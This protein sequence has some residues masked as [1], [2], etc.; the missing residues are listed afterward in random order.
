MAKTKIPT[1][2]ASCS[3][4]T[5]PE[6][7]L[8]AKLKAI[9][10]AG[11]DAI[12]L[13]LPDL[14]SFAKSYLKKDGSNYDYPELCEA[15]EKVK[16]LCEECNLK[17]LIL[18]PFANFEGWPDGSSEKE[19]AWKRA[20]GWIQIMEAVGTDMLQVCCCSGRNP[21]C[22][23]KAMRLTNDS[24]IFRLARL[25]RQISNRP[26][27]SLRVILRI[28]RIFWLPKASA[29]HMRTGAGQHM[30]QHGERCGRSSRRLTGQILGY[31]WIHFKLQGASGQTL[32]QSRD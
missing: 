16:Q 30:R 14:L 24:T 13:S 15:G 5:K 29:L 3:I 28:S 31:V 11:F 6:H 27:P 2:Y 17:I 18:Q 32:Q 22:R 12:E 1:C 4:G 9:S 20:N 21:H 26:K 19:N 23:A 7:D 8:P 25:T 10:A